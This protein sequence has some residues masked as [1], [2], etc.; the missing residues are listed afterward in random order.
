MGEKGIW[1]FQFINKILANI[2]EEAKGFC[3]L[4]PHTHTHTLD[5]SM[6]Q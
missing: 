6:K 2:L 3:V 1:D 5:K 4:P